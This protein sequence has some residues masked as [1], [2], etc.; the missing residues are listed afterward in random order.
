MSLDAALNGG[1]SSLQTVQR[2]ISVISNNINNA[3]TAGYTKKTT[4]TEAVGD[5]VNLVGVKISSIARATDANLLTAV[6]LAASNNSK[7][8]TQQQYL[9]QLQGILGIG[10]TNAQLFNTIQTFTADWNLYQAEPENVALQSQL[11]S[12]GTAVANTIRIISN[13]VE[14]L[15][16]SII[17]DIAGSVSELNQAL[18]TIQTLNQQIAD[19]ASG[20]LPTGDYEDKRDQAVRTVAQFIDIKVQQNGNSQIAIYTPQGYNLLNGDA[21]QFAFDGT[22]ITL[23]GGSTAIQDNLKG[24]KLEA[25]INLRA[26]TSP[27]AASTDPTMEV[28]RKLRAQLN[29]IADGFL[30]ATTGPDSFAQ[31]YDSATT[32][33]GELASGFFTGTDRTNITVN[34]ALIAGT[35]KV[36]QLSAVP[37]S[38]AMT[39]RTRSFTAAGLTTSNVSYASYAQTVISVWQTA[40]TQI[41][42]SAETAKSELDYYDKLY[43]D[44]TSVNVDE[45]MIK[46]QML[47][48]AYQA[49][50]RLIGIIQQMNETITQIVR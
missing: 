44:K 7:L 21:E 27:A 11:I 39:D 2:Q 32:G 38:N 43:T 37:V 13:R 45:E 46:L 12:D 49:A 28:I 31:A 23:L 29:A 47:Q 36:K 41:N 19:A 30:T 33:T 3:N 18:Q 22:N 26:D 25:L 16:R 14:E 50:A 20:G 35:S 34:A 6:N 17:S 15:D 42:A 1:L 40:G 4:Q 24:G 5:G 8:D 9:A 48:V 10:N